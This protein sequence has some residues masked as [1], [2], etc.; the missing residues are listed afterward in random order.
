MG[1]AVPSMPVGLSCAALLLSSSATAAF[2][3][4]ALVS[5][6]VS[7]AVHGTTPGAIPVGRH[8][9]HAVVVR[10]ATP[11][12]AA[13]VKGYF[14]LG[15][16]LLLERRDEDV[17]AF[18]EKER[19]RWREVYEE[20]CPDSLLQ[21]IEYYPGDRVEIVGDVQVKEIENA[22]GMRGFVTHY[23]FDDGYESCQ[24]CSTTRPVAVLL[25]R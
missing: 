25:D 6:H 4:P 14:A 7:H 10:R 23:E 2:N 19:H 20:E 21:S 9:S 1:A 18:N 15:E 24:T 3:A 11:Q 13:G 22:K 17:A 8:V 5:S 16:V 12:M